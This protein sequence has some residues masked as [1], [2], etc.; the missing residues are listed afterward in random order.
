MVRP[1][2][3]RGRMMMG[4]RVAGGEQGLGVGPGESAGRMAQSRHPP[5]RFAE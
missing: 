1:A 5:D 3:D 4:L 2:Y